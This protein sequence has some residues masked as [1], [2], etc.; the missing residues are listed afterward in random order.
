MRLPD[1][2][3]TVLQT[4]TTGFQ[5]LQALFIPIIMGVSVAAMSQPSPAGSSIKFMFALVSSQI[6]LFAFQRAACIGTFV[7]SGVYV[8]LVDNSGIDICGYDPKV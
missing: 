7:D 1:A 4:A 3:P 2:N 5:F 6:L 8:V